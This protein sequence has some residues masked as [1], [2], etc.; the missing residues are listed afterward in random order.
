MSNTNKTKFDPIPKD[1]YLLR[2][3]K[4]ELKNTKAGGKMISVGFQVVKSDVDGAKGRL[5]FHNFITE[6]AN[7]IV[8]EIGLKQLDEYLAAVGINGGYEELG[9]SVDALQET[10]ELPFLGNVG[11]QE[12]NAKGDGT[13]WDDKNVILKDG[14]NAR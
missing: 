11:I 12:G 1:Q 8:S 13:F 9:Y 14:F 2:M 4:A 3:N 10:L 6:H 5:I 7:P